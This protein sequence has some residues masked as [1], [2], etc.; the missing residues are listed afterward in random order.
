MNNFTFV[1]KLIYFESNSMLSS[2][3]NEILY[4]KYP[5]YCLDSK[6][7]KRPGRNHQCPQGMTVL[8]NKMKI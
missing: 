8:R 7:I 1:F 5:A 2:V 3:L 6:G 4:M